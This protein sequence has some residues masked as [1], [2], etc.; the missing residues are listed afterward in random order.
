[1]LSSVTTAQLHLTGLRTTAGPLILEH[2]VQ[3][4]HHEA[5]SSQPLA[6]PLVTS[7]QELKE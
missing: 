2:R 3:S 7:F 6:K 5:E 4:A 1:M